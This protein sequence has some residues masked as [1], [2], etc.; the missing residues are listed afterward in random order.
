MQW[1]Q[2]LD[3]RAKLWVTFLPLGLIALIIVAVGFY[4]MDR[5]HAQ[6]ETIYT[7]HLAPL[8]SISEAEEALGQI[9]NH[10][11]QI[12]RE[13]DADLD[14]IEREISGL[15]DDLEEHLSQAADQGAD[16]QSTPMDEA[17]NEWDALRTQT[18]QLIEQAREDTLD[19]D[20]AAAYQ[21]AAQAFGGTLDDLQ[22]DKVER[23]EAA[24]DESQAVYRTSTT[25]LIATSAAGFLLSGLLA[26][27]VA[28]LV[29]RPLGKLDTAA[30]AVAEGNYDTQVEVDSDDEIGRLAD[31]FN[32]M[33][34]RIKSKVEEAEES[35]A[36]AE[37]AAEKAG[38][39]ADQQEREKRELARHIDTMLDA[40]EEFADGDLTVSLDARQDGDIGRLFRGFND[41]VSTVRTTMA[42][43]VKTVETIAVTTTE[44]SA[45]TD[46]LA[47]GAEEQSAQADEVA[48]AMEEMSSTIMS[49]A[50]ATTET[51]S[52]SQETR[53]TAQENGQAIIETVEKMEEIGD[54]V[55]RSTETVKQLEA[56]SE[57][58]GDI[59]ETID[60]IAEQTNLLA[61]NAA[62][63]AARAGEHG[64]GFAVVADEVRELAERT[65]EA[66]DEIA[67]MIS[68]IQT[69]TSTAVAAMEEG[70]RE[71]QNGID[72]ADRARSAF[73]EIV[74][75]TEKV[76]Q[77]IDE[78][79]TATEE[80]SSTTEQIS[81]NVESISTVSQQNAEAIHEIA[82][83]VK[84]LDDAG[85][86]LRQLVG[87]FTIDED[88][89]D[90]DAVSQMMGG[91]GA[92]GQP[93]LESTD[94]RKPAVE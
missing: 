24:Q 67:T 39:L 46:Q 51:A 74:A 35:Q 83:V 76:D 19:S 45:S 89:S 18:H 85:A 40:M 60:E 50:Q 21:T 63:E 87:R 28:R 29:S 61:L 49:N 88:S 1:F 80:Q 30:N 75:G 55:S 91:D 42:Q 66:T 22:A 15:E 44:A 38:Q 3:M 32:T 53:E 23:A 79:A 94:S 54:V 20:S 12:A 25:V 34:T 16:E 10:A 93:D 41:A 72:L 5:T 2:N 13:D 33:T 6:N 81:R 8:T 64:D 92:T 86:E 69:E 48:T 43:V 37:S 56:S 62:I 47:T 4:G 82:Q 57:A 59:V 27:G 78:I 52:V 11:R 17:K 65:A 9:Q 77:R 58:I 36:R 26:F 73:E 14:A 70:H 84:E 71:V 90:Q 68:D 31:S 7:E